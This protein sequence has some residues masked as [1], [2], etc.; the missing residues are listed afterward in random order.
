MGVGGRRELV[1]LER[2]RMF[3]NMNILILSRLRRGINIMER[4]LGRREGFGWFFF[5]FFL[6]FFLGLGSRTFF[7]LMLSY[8]YHAIFLNFPFPPRYGLTVP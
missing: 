8:S 1:S 5:S 6:S 2:L 3:L 4:L 7:F